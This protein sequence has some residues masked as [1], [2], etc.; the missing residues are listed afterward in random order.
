MGEFE[1]RIKVYS[2]YIK[3]YP[4]KLQ[5]V[6]LIGYKKDIGGDGSKEPDHVIKRYIL[7]AIR[8]V[9]IFPDDHGKVVWS[10]LTVF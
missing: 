4:D 7:V 9:E 3:E 2:D 6:R 8:H 1:G 10:E 5:R